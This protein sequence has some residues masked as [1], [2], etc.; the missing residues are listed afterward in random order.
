MGR[1]LFT[2]RPIQSRV[3]CRTSQTFSEVSQQN[4]PRHSSEQ[5][6]YVKK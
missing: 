1:Y 3:K 6:K 4:G 5:L 2:L